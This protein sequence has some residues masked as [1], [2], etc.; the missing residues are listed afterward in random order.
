MR[1][2]DTSTKLSPPSSKSVTTVDARRPPRRPL[3]RA[4]SL[5]SCG[6]SRRV[7]AARE[8]RLKRRHSRACA[9][10]SANRLVERERGGGRSPSPS[11]PPRPF[12]RAPPPVGRAS[13]PT[14]APAGS[15]GPVSYQYSSIPA[16]ARDGWFEGA[17]ARKRAKGALPPPSSL[18]L[19]PPPPAARRAKAP[20]LI[21]RPF[22]S[23]K[24]P[25]HHSSTVAFLIP[26]YQVGS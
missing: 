3:T 7:R 23:L 20:E 8:R 17:R 11:D 18:L 19:S 6:G 21:F 5:P 24:N 10:R 14:I 16:G 15:R 1:R 13:N 2:R 9:L 4:A 25:Q 22:S 26:G 12:A